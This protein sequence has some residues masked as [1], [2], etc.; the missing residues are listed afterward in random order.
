MDIFVRLYK[1]YDIDL[2]SLSAAGYDLSRMLYV[3]LQSFASGSPC[4]IM[5]NR[6]IDMGLEDIQNLRIRCRIQK[7][8]E[9]VKDLLSGIKPKQRNA[10][11]KALLR[12]T[13]SCGNLRLFLN[14]GDYDSSIIKGRSLI[15]V[16][17]TNCVLS[18]D[19]FKKGNECGMPLLTPPPA[20]NTLKIPK[21]KKKPKEAVTTLPTAPLRPEI[22]NDKPRHKDYNEVVD[23]STDNTIAGLLDEFP[24]LFG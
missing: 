1:N 20:T 22:K 6:D 13:L 5:L 12:N 16:T 2:I 3:S 14:T 21:I 24:G 10:F 23:V 9:H 11:C 7:D 8:C 15:A 19:D 4:K 17:D 18:I